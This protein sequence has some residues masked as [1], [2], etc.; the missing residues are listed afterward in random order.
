MP[1]PFPMCCGIAYYRCAWS[2]LLIG[3]SRLV[4][5]DTTSCENLALNHLYLAVGELVPDDAWCQRP[6]QMTLCSLAG[7][8]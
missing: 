2:C 8:V 7:E 5:I 6:R 4:M 3:G 1:M